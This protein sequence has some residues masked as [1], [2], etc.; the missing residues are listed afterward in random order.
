MNLYEN[1]SSYA[2]VNAQN[3]LCGRTHYV[4]DSTLRFHKGRILRAKATC[5]GLLFYIIESCAADMHNTRRIFRPVIFDI[6]GHVISRPALEDGCKTRA[7][8]EKMLWAEMEKIDNK[9]SALAAVDRAEKY[10]MEDYVR[11]REKI[12]KA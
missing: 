1:N 12:S 2:K 10:A 8:A 5:D 7:Q 3:N 6:A 9:A 11:I 4:D